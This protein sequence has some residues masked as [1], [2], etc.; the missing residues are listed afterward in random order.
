[1]NDRPVPFDV[2]SAVVTQMLIELIE[3]HPE[4]LE[5][6]RERLGT[7]PTP[8]GRFIFLE[9]THRSHPYDLKE[10]TKPWTT[11]PPKVQ[12]SAETSSWSR[13]NIIRSTRR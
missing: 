7:L 3:K 11:N 4:L 5:E 9:L 1:M 2:Q 6:I 12:S 13:G 10:L 8:V